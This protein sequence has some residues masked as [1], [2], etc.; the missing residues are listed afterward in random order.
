MSKIPERKSNVR[1]K[2][3]DPKDTSSGWISSVAAVL[4]GKSLF[5][6]AATAAVI[7]AII[8][9][10]IL[11]RSTSQAIKNLVN[12]D[13]D[14]L[15]DAFFGNKP[16]LFVC[17]RELGNNKIGTI[18]AIF[19][20]LNVIKGNTISFATVNCSQVLP[21]GK[22]IMERFKLKKEWKPT[23]FGTAP[24]TKPI[25]AQPSALANV[26]SL[27]KF[28]EDSLAPKA[29]VVKSDK[30]LWQHC[31]FAKNLVY[32]DRDISET[33]VLLVKGSKFSSTTA[34]LEQRL[35]QSYP[36]VKFAMVD[37]SKL[38]MT[39]EDPDGMPPD[40]FALKV[41][42]LRNGTH[43][44]SMV[45]P[46]TWDYL[47]TFVSSA[48]AAPLYDYQ[49]DSSE[50]VHLMK[51]K[52]LRVIKERK[53]KRRAAQ[54]QAKEKKRPKVENSQ[55]SASKTKKTGPSK[56][57]SQRKEEAEEIINQEDISMDSNTDADNTAAIEE[58][59][60]KREQARREEMERQQ[61]ESVFTDGDEEDSR[62]VDDGEDA[63]EDD[64]VIEL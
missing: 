51:L 36:Q 18:P 7:L 14:S 27:K 6:Q 25:Q 35:V 30:H 45:H 9:G 53:A 19:S 55:E 62:T 59:R 41:H 28:A 38:R 39:F 12:A 29:T 56:S 26:Q 42:A 11:Y 43:F 58:N 8:F 34:Q 63:E 3:V 20:D 24:W 52:D 32:D 37:A 46:I 15:K 33:C 44:Q 64:S 22:T 60:R 21:S 47:N 48:V 5:R 40:Y 57:S 1:I 4:F 23:I 10:V 31:A 49:G 50:T 54:D 17:D 2:K 13:P 16:H 61:R